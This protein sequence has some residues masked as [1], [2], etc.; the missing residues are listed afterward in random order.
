MPD[1]FPS[2]RKPQNLTRV[3]ERARTR[4]KFIFDSHPIAPVP[5]RR[6]PQARAQNPCRRAP[7][8]RFPLLF[9]YTRAKRTNSHSR[10][11]FA[12]SIR[13]CTGIYRSI[14]YPARVRSAHKIVRIIYM[15]VRQP[16]PNSFTNS[17]AKSVR[18]I[19]LRP[20]AFAQYRSIYLLSPERLDRHYRSIKRY[21]RVRLSRRFAPAN[22]F[23]FSI[24][25]R[26]CNAQYRSIIYNVRAHERAFRSIILHAPARTERIVRRIYYTRV[27]PSRPNRSI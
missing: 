16:L 12:T 2:P 24:Y 25:A 15:R 3:C 17:H 7:A 9:P 1:E 14:I 19:Y 10:A 11:S 23:D 5:S 18:I 26:V 13:A 20:C 6:A 27:H 4:A 21:S 22:S 8:P